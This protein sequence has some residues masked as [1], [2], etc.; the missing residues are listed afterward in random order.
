MKLAVIP[1]DGIGPEVINQALKVLK[2]VTEKYGVN[3]E[4]E[5]V[6]MGGI[7]IDKT[8]VPLPQETIDIC[9]KSDAVLLG[10]VGGEKW[11]TLPGHLRPEAG[12]LGIRKALD[13]YANLRP[14]IVFPQL[15]SASMLKEEALKDGLDVMIIRE[16]IGGSYF[17]EKK[18][19]KLEDGTYKAWDTQLYTTAEIT[20]IT[21]MAFNIAKKR[22]NKLTLVDKAN[23]LESSRL[24]REVV[25]DIAKSYPEV[26][27]NYM[28]VDNA[29]MQLIRKPSQFN[30][31]LT[32]NM[33]GDILSDEASM[34]TGSL[35]M[36]PSASLGDGNVGLYEPIHGS[37]PDIAGQD[38]ANP[39]ATIMSTALMLKYS[40]NMDAAA[41]D[42]E[43]AINKVLDMGYRTLDI[44]SEG[45]Q[46]VGCEKMGDLIIEQLM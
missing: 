39:L 34:I 35:G 17:G 22:E 38:K 33:F 40:F 9:K 12:L 29:A 6:L 45:K 15:K 10:A 30:V 27:L 41:K 20:R 28:Y 42:I 25:T 3:L 21:H 44:M 37:A 1:G 36:L 7:A 4:T 31:I 14:A 11:D 46:A 23:V 32:E 13:V 5:E 2:V 8:G 43:E 19:V 18:R 16:L 26:E 24:W